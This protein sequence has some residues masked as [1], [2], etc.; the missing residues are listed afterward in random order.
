[1]S[2]NKGPVPKS[3]A[4]AQ[5]RSAGL[6]KYEPKKGLQSVAVAEVAEKYY[7]RAKDAVGLE[8][9]IRA[10][11]THQ[12]E[13]VFWWDTKGPGANHGGDRQGSGRKQSTS[14]TADLEKGRR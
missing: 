9:A 7:A 4:L 12:A 5:R 14:A 2:A 3:R 1:M 11:L 8:R 6:S 13:F 10:K